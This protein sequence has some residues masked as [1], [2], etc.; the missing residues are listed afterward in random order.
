[1]GS[2]KQPPI[3]FA[4]TIL[5]PAFILLRLISSV[6]RADELTWDIQT[7]YSRR[8]QP[9]KVPSLTV[10]PNVT[11]VAPGS[12]LELIAQPHGGESMRFS[13]DWKIIRGET[14]A[15]LH[16][17][18][19]YDAGVIGANVR[20]DFRRNGSGSVQIRAQ[21]HEYPDAYADILVTI[22]P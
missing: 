5:I 2:F 15:E 19:E 7:K 9:V 4:F 12:S 18:P 1:M 14:K 17:K 6:T 16:M 13:I 3:K 20:V 22:S 11:T 21:L 8:F 10:T